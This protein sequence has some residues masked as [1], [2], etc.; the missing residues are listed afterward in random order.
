LVICR[1]PD[2]SEVRWDWA[3][4][5]MNEPPAKPKDSCAVLY[6]AERLMNPGEE[7]RL[8]FTYGLGKLYTTGEGG[9]DGSG[10]GGSG[11]LRL[12]TAGS[13]RVGKAFTATAYVKASLA[14]HKIKLVLPAGL[15]RAEGQKVDQEVPKA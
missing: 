6:W 1:W 7:R 15:S 2:N 12:L 14:G 3:Y 8:G 11:R 10:G 9:T 13:S 5:A 4:T